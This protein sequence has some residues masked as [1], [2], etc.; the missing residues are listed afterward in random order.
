MRSI[1]RILA[2]VCAVAAVAALPLFAGDRPPKDTAKDTVDKTPRLLGRLFEPNGARIVVR[3]ERCL[4]D[5]LDGE[6]DI[7]LLTVGAEKTRAGEPGNEVNQNDEKKEVPF[8]PIATFAFDR[9]VTDREPGQ[10]VAMWIYGPSRPGPGR[11]IAGLAPVPAGSPGVSKST[12]RRTEQTIAALR[13]GNYENRPS[14]PGAFIDLTET[15]RFP[16]TS[17]LSMW[18]RRI[19]SWVDVNNPGQFLY[20]AYV[21]RRRDR[22]DRSFQRAMISLYWLLDSEVYQQPDRI[23][24]ESIKDLKFHLIR[25]RSFWGRFLSAGDAWDLVLAYEGTVREYHGKNSAWMHVAA[26]EHYLRYEPIYRYTENGRGSPMAGVL[27]YDPKIPD[28]HDPGWWD[29]F[30]PFDLTYNPHKNRRIQALARE[31]P[32]EL[33]PLAVYTY[34]TELGLRP[35]IT[36]DFFD[37]G[38]PRVRERNQVLMTYAGH[39][40]SMETGVLSLQRLPFRFGTWAAN[41]KGLTLVT[42]MSSRMGVEELRMAVEAGLYFRD[43]ALRLMLRQADKRAINPL[44]HPSREQRLRA[45]L[46]YETLRTENYR[47]FCLEVSRVR[48]T[49]MERAGISKFT[50]RFERRRM[51]AQILESRRHMNK[52]RT[53]RHRATEEYGGL[54]KLSEPL[55]YFAT[56]KPPFPRRLQRVLRRT[57]QELRET[58]MT[59][60]AGHGLQDVLALR[61]RT[62]EVWRRV[63]KVQGLEGFDATLTESEVR[64]QNTVARR[65]RKAEKRQR[66]NLKKMFT[67]GHRRLRRAADSGCDPALSSDADVEAYLVMLRDLAR[68]ATVSDLV[69]AELDRHRV[70]LTEVVMSVEE[71]YARCEIPDEE[72]WRLGNRETGLELTR[73]LLA[74]L[75]LTHAPVV[76]GDEN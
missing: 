17:G 65:G 47:G 43:D 52:L 67:M 45:Q 76:T 63:S 4:C 16:R 10:W 23:W 58:E 75:E 20:R 3:R 22:A 39:W 26:N 70:E 54:Q 74:A 11:T 72:S 37:P 7:L 14:F 44:V 64:V 41:K 62:E 6:P 36:I 9:S 29:N 38:N 35:I 40:V 50:P 57:Y 12:L 15:G 59:L 42:S 13:A 60:P 55:D 48:R 8:Q 27:Y 33:I 71:T 1:V 18:L 28:G 49:L 69:R 56:A 51:L 21:A 73:S 19:L 68:A 34:Q 66:G 25:T 46:Q 61:K 53:L 5:S 31:N 30:N 2:L 24:L 32:D